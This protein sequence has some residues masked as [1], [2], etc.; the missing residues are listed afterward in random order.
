MDTPGIFQRLSDIE[1]RIN[2]LA[3][4][5]DRQRR[6]TQQVQQ[7]AILAG[8]GGNPSQQYSMPDILAK[9]TSGTIAAGGATVK[10]VTLITVTGTLKTGQT[11]DVVNTH[12]TEAVPSN[13]YCWINVVDGVWA[14]KGW[15]C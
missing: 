2:D 6:A 7:D 8:G 3:R 1:R 12:P 13:A 4:L 10:T 14:V 5:A 9:A 15:Y 11:R